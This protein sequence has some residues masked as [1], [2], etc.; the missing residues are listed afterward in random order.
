MYF[1]FKCAQKQN[2]CI[3]KSAILSDYQLWF[4]SKQQNCV[5]ICIMYVCIYIYM[6]RQGLRL[7]DRRTELSLSCCYSEFHALC[8]HQTAGYY[9]GWRLVIEYWGVNYVLSL[10]R[11]AK[12]YLFS[13]QHFETSSGLLLMVMGLLALI[14]ESFSVKQRLHRF[15]MLE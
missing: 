4:L 12:W 6:H 9:S 11:C 3:D 2:T 15:V 5:Y 10:E 7:K 13:C 8:D 1:F 14:M